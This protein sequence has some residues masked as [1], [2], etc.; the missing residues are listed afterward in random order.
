MPRSRPAPRVSEVLVCNLR[1]AHTGPADP[2]Y[3]DSARR[4]LAAVPDTADDYD[5]VLTWA[6]VSTA[7]VVRICSRTCPDALVT[8]AV[9]VAQRALTDVAPL[10]RPLC[11]RWP[12]QP[13]FSDLLSR[14]GD[15]L[16]ALDSTA[17][18][19]AEGAAEDVARLIRVVR[20]YVDR[21]SRTDPVAAL[22]QAARTALAARDVAHSAGPE[23]LVS[24]SLAVLKASQTASASASNAMKRAGPSVISVHGIETRRAIL[25]R[26]RLGELVRGVG[27]RTL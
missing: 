1:Y 19:D 17:D 14:A 6:H 7:D 13:G 21:A 26:E 5:A 15:L 3:V 9:V 25:A 2:L 22:I 10:I 23:M 11:W 16:A 12:D 18:A 24:R 4:V 8:W 27:A 20:P